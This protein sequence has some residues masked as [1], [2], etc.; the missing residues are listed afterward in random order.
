MN[1]VWEPEKGSSSKGRWKRE[2]VF[3][4][5]M[6]F[7]CPP[8]FDSELVDCKVGDIHD[9]I[10]ELV[11]SNL[12][13]IVHDRHRHPI[14]RH[15]QRLPVGLPDQYPCWTRGGWRRQGAYILIFNFGASIDVQSAVWSCYICIKH[16]LLPQ[17]IGPSSPLRI[18]SSSDSWISRSSCHCT[19]SHRWSGASVSSSCRTS[20]SPRSRRRRTA[21]PSL[22]GVK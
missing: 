22:F 18:S 17:H 3:D 4:G 21:A 10:H 13:S 19:T 16:H 20:I 5:V 9:G 2:V 14:P 8:S 15:G 12:T 6:L 1:P 11:D 7:S